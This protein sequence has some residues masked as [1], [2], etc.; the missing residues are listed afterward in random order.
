MFYSCQGEYRINLIEEWKEELQ[1]EEIPHSE[2]CTLVGT[3]GD[4]VKIRNW[5]IAGLP[6]DT[7][8]V[9]NGIIVQFSKRWP[10]F[11]DPQ[12][13]ANKWIRSQVSLNV[14]EQICSKQQ[15]LELFKCSNFPCKAKISI[16]E[17]L[18]AFFDKNCIFLP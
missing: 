8:S 17:L 2:N 6:R 13:Q 3:L 9:D 11:I 16:L 18:W 1:K 15:S 4:P 12:G 14:I 10:L 5:Q 7:L